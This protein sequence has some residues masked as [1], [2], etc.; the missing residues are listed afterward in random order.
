MCVILSLLCCC[1][2]Q[3]EPW[4]LD[5]P[6]DPSLSFLQEGSISEEGAE[7]FQA[8]E[9]AVAVPSST[10]PSTEDYA[11]DHGF[12]LAFKQS[13]TAKSVT[14]TVRRVV[15]FGFGGEVVELGEDP[16]S[17]SGCPKAIF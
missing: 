5:L 11:G 2:C 14:C 16:I 10:V 17:D 3:T 8:L 6:D 7:I 12:E 1:C 9:S 13:G 4:D 15:G